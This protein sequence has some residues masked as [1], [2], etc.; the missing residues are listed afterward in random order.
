[1][2]IVTLDGVEYQIQ[3]DKLTGWGIKSAKAHAIG[4]AVERKQKVTKA[5]KITVEWSEK[6]FVTPDP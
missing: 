1:M 2:F 5:T 4:Q 3:A 6:P